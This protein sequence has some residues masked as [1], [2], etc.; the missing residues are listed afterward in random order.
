MRVEDVDKGPGEFHPF[1]EPGE[2]TADMES[3][4]IAG[5]G[6]G[7]RIRSLHRY[8]ERGAERLLRTKT[9]TTPFRNTPQPLLEDRAD[10]ICFNFEQCGRIGHT[11]VDLKM[12]FGQYYGRL[13]RLSG[14]GKGT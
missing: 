14:T 9:G 6:N 8:N 10:T 5:I 13:G 7:E 11:L 4:A 12:L 1:R 3:A 2:V